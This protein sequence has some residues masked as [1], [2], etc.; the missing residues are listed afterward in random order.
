MSVSVHTHTPMCACGCRGH[1]PTMAGAA[2]ATGAVEQ[3]D[4]MSNT[5]VV[6]ASLRPAAAYR[7]GRPVASVDGSLCKQFHPPKATKQRPRSTFELQPIATLA[8]LSY[9]R[10]TGPLHDPTRFRDPEVQSSSTT[11]PL[12]SP[13]STSC[14]LGGSSPIA[15]CTALNAAAAL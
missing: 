6:C 1:A 3:N 9:I 5:V 13:T 10:S 4:C 14:V 8:Q 11:R 15:S 12:P 2:C 7:M